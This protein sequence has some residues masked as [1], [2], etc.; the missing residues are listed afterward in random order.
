MPK[1]LIKAIID[2]EKIEEI[3]WA[4]SEE[5]AV[6]MFTLSVRWVDSKSE[7]KIVSVD[8]KDEIIKRLKGR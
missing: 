4:S 6:A 5:E 7:I 2:G 1:Y 3:L 8:L